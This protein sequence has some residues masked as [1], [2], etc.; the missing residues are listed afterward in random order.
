MKRLASAIVLLLCAILPPA[1]DSR[2]SVGGC[3]FAQVPYGYA[4]AS[5]AD[6]EIAGLGGGINEYVQVMTCFD[7]TADPA[8]A[9]MKGRKIVGVRCYLRAAY[10]QA[11]QKRSA[12]LASQGS[13]SAIIRQKSLGDGKLW[14]EAGRYL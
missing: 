6:G 7:P 12:V 11:R 13:V 2:L 9:R 8:I 10:S 4:P 3:A 14:T 5:V 1:P